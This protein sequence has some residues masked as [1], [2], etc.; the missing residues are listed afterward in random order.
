[1][2]GNSPGKRPPAADL[3]SA[4]AEQGVVAQS[5]DRDQFFHHTGCTMMKTI[6]DLMTIATL[7]VVLLV[8]K[9]L[10]SQKRPLVCKRVEALAANY[11]S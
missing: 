3:S 9:F 2:P 6:R 11:D 4:G 1:M 10:A 8:A 7:C 5:S